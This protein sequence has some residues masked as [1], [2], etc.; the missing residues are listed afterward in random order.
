MNHERSIGR[1]SLREIVRGGVGDLQRAWDQTEAAAGFDPLPSGVYR[2]I[3]DSGE[4]T[5]SRSNGTPGLKLRLVV[6]DGE[7][8]GRRLFHD[9]WL[10]ADSMSRAKYE[11]GQLGITQLDQLDRPLPAGLTAEVTVICRTGDDGIPY[12]KVRSFK[13]IP[14]EIPVDD[15]APPPTEEGAP[16]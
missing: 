9:V 11:L 5:T 2:V 6:L 13:A 1:R 10:T 4:L 16:E 3:V 12:N 7:H 15:F 8:R 14:T